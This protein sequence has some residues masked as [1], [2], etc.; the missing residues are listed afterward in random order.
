[1]HQSENNAQEQADQK[2]LRS[3]MARISHKILVLSGKGGVGKSTVAVNLALSLMLEGKRVGLL[4][5]DIHGPSVPTHAGLEG[6]PIHTAAA[7]RCCPW[8]WAT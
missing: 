8:S 6:E 2:K 5:V 1:M 3:R 7:T 4:D